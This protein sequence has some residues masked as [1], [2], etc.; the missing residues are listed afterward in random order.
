M[1]S[2]RDYV[3]YRK[4]LSVVEMATDPH[5]FISSEGEEKKTSEIRRTPI[6][7][8]KDD[9][10]YL[11]N[12]PT[13]L[14]KQALQKRWGELLYNVY[15]NKEQ[16]GPA[17]PDVQPITLRYK[18]S[19]LTFPNVDTKIN[20]LY[21]RLSADPGNEIY[22]TMKV[23]GTAKDREEFSKKAEELSKKRGKRVSEYG[24]N[25]LDWIR[26]LD[27]K[28]K[29]KAGVAS[30]YVEP[31]ETEVK[32]ALSRLFHGMEYGWFDKDI[33]PHE[34]K[35]VD[36]GGNKKL[37]KIP[38]EDSPKKWIEGV[39]FTVKELKS[40]KS[41]SGKTYARKRKPIEIESHVPIMA[42]GFMVPSSK[43]RR[44][45]WLVR[46]ARGLREDDGSNLARI[47][48]FNADWDNPEV[49]LVNEEEYKKAFE[50]RAALNRQILE[51]RNKLKKQ[52]FD[53]EDEDLED[54]DNTDK[55]TQS[56]SKK[57]IKLKNELVEEDKVI[58]LAQKL[59]G[60][61]RR[62]LLKHYQNSKKSSTDE[63]SAKSQAFRLFLGDVASF[64]DEISKRLR[65]RT[66]RYDVHQWNIFQYS[67]THEAERPQGRLS[68][69]GTYQPNK[70]QPE[71]IYSLVT[72]ILGKENISGFWNHLFTETDLRKYVEDGIKSRAANAVSEF[73]SVY[74]MFV[75][76]ISESI[77]EYNLDRVTTDALQQIQFK[78]GN[79]AIVKYAEVYKNYVLNEKKNS[80]A[81]P[82]EKKYQWAILKLYK[83]ARYDASNYC[84]QLIQLHLR[85]ALQRWNRTFRK[86]NPWEPSGKGYT[87]KQIIQAFQNN[88]SLPAYLDPR[89]SH[90]VQHVQELINYDEIK[91][92]EASVL[93]VGSSEI[94]NSE[95][96]DGI[97]IR[98]AQKTTNQSVFGKAIELLFD[99]I[100]GAGSAIGSLLKPKAPQQPNVPAQ[101]VP[102]QQDQKEEEPKKSKGWS[103]I[104][105]FFK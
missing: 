70:Q 86:E 67:N 51:I 53:F 12:F 89:T 81:L 23:T 17:V 98:T 21:D 13:I 84:K 94:Q 74:S 85:F 39:D 96:E 58:K 6:F 20:E 60:S 61:Y 52:G 54:A 40:V 28:G 92:L 30:G 9:I 46:T 97:N 69:F 35:S 1:R 101:K 8:D 41:K 24:F 83:F 73:D 3:N 75:Q 29:L 15:L 33:G 87:L 103:D 56:L 34:K 68:G 45:E 88:E 25:F 19:Q 105:G 32:A 65:D 49:N 93:K 95:D 82:N 22:R 62:F 43:K 72:D 59:R 7:L 37:R 44:N 78:T 66:P 71:R 18:S 104:L 5:V 80:A 99:K 76:S 31:G 26:K 63:I 42:P 79:V 102:A 2:F 91:G 16:G 27:E 47:I 50:K 14:W 57:I 36:V 90:A 64:L 77:I 55:A 11:Q 4:N 38:V 48:N 10:S 100:K